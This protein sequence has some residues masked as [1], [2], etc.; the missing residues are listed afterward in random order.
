MEFKSP[1]KIN[2]YKPNLKTPLYE[3]EISHIMFLSLNCDSKILI[4]KN[5]LCIITVFF[6]VFQN[7]FFRLIQLFRAV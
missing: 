7:S 3:H 1:M 2:Y 6:L 4:C 5:F